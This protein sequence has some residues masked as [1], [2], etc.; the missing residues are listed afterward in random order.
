MLDKT[1]PHIDIVLWSLALI[2]GVVL[3]YIIPHLRYPTYWYCSV[4][5]SFSSLSYT[6]SQVSHL[7][8]NVPSFYY[9]SY[10][11]LSYTTSQEYYK[12]INVVPS[13]YDWIYYLLSYTTYWL[14]WFLAH[15]IEVILR[16]HICIQNTS[17][18]I[19][20]KPHVDIWSCFFYKN[21][22]EGLNSYVFILIQNNQQS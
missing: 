13:S 17:S 6:T 10:S 9:W 15:I 18:I 8:K 22:K 14:I 4:V 2:V 20:G 7:L 3:H 5:G 19:L 21:S 12:L 1:F 16:Y 11:S